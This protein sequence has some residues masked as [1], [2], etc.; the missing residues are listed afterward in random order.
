MTV[1]AVTEVSR[2][3]SVSWSLLLEGS[4]PAQWVLQ[5]PIPTASMMTGFCRHLPPSC[6]SLV[7]WQHSLLDISLQSMGAQGLAH[8]NCSTH[9]SKDACSQVLATLHWSC[10]LLVILSSFFYDSCAKF[11][12]LVTALFASRLAAV[13]ACMYTCDG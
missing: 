6:T 2:V 8:D 9:N 3:A 1:Q 10:Q 4:S 12:L 13:Q 5:T 11:G 7:L